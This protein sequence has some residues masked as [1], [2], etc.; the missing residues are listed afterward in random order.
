M[1]SANTGKTKFFASL[2]PQQKK[3]VLELT[4]LDSAKAFRGLTPK[5]G[6]TRFFSTNLTQEQKCDALKKWK[7]KHDLEQKDVKGVLFKCEKNSGK[8]AFFAQLTDQ[9]KLAVLRCIP[10]PAPAD[11]LKLYTKEYK[12]TSSRFT[13]KADH[14]VNWSVTH[15]R[16]LVFT[17]KASCNG[18]V[19]TNA[20]VSKLKGALAFEVGVECGEDVQETVTCVVPPRSKVVLEEA[21]QAGTFASQGRR[22]SFTLVSDCQLKETPLD[23]N[24]S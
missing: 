11:E 15:T 23:E 8:T 3:E 21:Q 10:R 4:G 14:E 12:P 6:K 16:R 24:P 19:E 20:L 1:P 22:L 2:S 13:N 18:E 17:R 5:E 7:D 9:E